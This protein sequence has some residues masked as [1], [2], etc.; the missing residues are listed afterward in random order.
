M[1][2]K[3][4]EHSLPSMARMHTIHLGKIL[5]NIA[6][7]GVALCAFFILSQILA[8]MGFILGFMLIVLTLG[9]ILLIPN[10]W[11]AI[12]S[13]LSLYDTLIA[14]GFIAA[15]PYILLISIVCCIASLVLLSLDKYEKHTGRIVFSYIILALCVLIGISMILQG[16]A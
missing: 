7:V 15:L 11:E 12:N 6:I 16:G 1:K 14:K 2:N 9:L 5:S 13:P 8:V 10:Y 4:I 3:I